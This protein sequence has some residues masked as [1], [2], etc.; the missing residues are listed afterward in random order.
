MT[1]LY[2]DPFDRPLTESLTDAEH[3]RLR[4]LDDTTSPSAMS[5]AAAR[6]QLLAGI[7][8]DTRTPAN[9]GAN[10][11]EPH[12]RRAGWFAAGAVAA[13]MA[14]TVVVVSLNG[15]SSSTPPAAQPSPS[16]GSAPAAVVVVPSISAPGSAQHSSSLP[17]PVVPPAISADRTSSTP[18][19]SAAIT[20]KPAPAHYAVEPVVF[21]KQAAAAAVANPAKAP[22]GDQFLYVKDGDY[23]AWLSMDGAHDGLIHDSAGGIDPEPG[24]VAGKSKWKN[25]DGSVA[26]TDCTADPAYFADAPTAPKAMADY[27]KTNA[28]SSRPNSLGKELMGI[29]QFKYLP[30]AAKA[31]LYESIPMLPGLELSG[32]LVDDNGGQVVSINW[33]YAGSTTT[34]F[35][36]P[37]TYAYLGCGT[38]AGDVQNSSSIVQA[39]V[40]KVGQR[41]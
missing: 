19:T 39:V 31:A 5:L 23:E 11:A 33:Q 28:G 26:T 32:Q 2:P 1:D 13:A 9:T 16:L 29:A 17:V 22:R 4:A 21:L 7:R 41:P 27:I 18:S 40:N 36:N 37:T 3:R 35:F 24:C 38:L 10:T 34:L 12:R 8:T 30:S 25:P 14:A 20:T 6:S 15:S